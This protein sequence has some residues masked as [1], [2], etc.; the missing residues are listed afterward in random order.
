MTIA[1]HR[2][3][4][5]AR[6]AGLVLLAAAI[7]FAQQE[8]SALTTLPGVD[9]TGLTAA[10]K[11]SALKVL[12]EHACPCGCDMKVAECRVKDPACSYSKGLSASLIES[13]KAGKSVPEAVKAAEASRWGHVPI[14]KLLDDPVTIPVAG[15]PVIGPA[16]ARITLVEFSDFQCPYCV[17]AVGQLKAILKAYPNDVKLI[18]KQF[19][20]DSH[21]QAAGAALAAIAAQKQGKF[22]EMHDAL[23]A[24]RDDLSR[25]ALFAVAESIGLDMKRFAADIDSPDTKRIVAHDMEDGE[26]AGVEG[27]PTL[28]I[29]GQ[30]YNGSLALDAIRQVL[31]GKLK[32]AS[33]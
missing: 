24:H 32:A 30:R 19:P 4:A 22:W 16:G 5:K 28:F 7:L 33:K 13:L 1:P 6:L 14:P 31:D 29:D 27:T 12:R 26:K 23:F 2:F 17:K 3:S 15:A 18:F 21:S 8:W 9:F 10:R 11:A 25:K 20:L